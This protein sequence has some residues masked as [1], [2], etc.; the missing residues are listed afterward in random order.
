MPH[1]IQQIAAKP[2]TPKM[3][4][5]ACAK[6]SLEMEFRCLETSEKTFVY[7][8]QRGRDSKEYHQNCHDQTVARTTAARITIAAETT[9]A[10]IAAF[11][12]G[13]LR[14]RQLPGWDFR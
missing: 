3:T 11:S 1:E 8:K 14:R 12:R 7:H 4:H 2:K 9:T 13:W 6:F 10:N 5:P